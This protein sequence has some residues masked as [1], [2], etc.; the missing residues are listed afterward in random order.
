M[1]ASE[2]DKDDVFTSPMSQ[3]LCAVRV[4]GNGYLSPTATVKQSMEVEG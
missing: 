1:Y 3:D 2:T 4:N